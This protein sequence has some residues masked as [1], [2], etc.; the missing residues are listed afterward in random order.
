MSL[1]DYLDGLAVEREF[2]PERAEEIDA[3]K[4]KWEAKVREIADAEAEKVRAGQAHDEATVLA[5]HIATPVEGDPLTST[6][7]ATGLAADSPIT[8]RVPLR[9]GAV[10]ETQISPPAGVAQDPGPSPVL[11]PDVAGNGSGV[12]ADQG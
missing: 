1:K 3:E 4:G 10:P 2:H 5:A 8:P 11:H 9:S 7:P 6:V 12:L